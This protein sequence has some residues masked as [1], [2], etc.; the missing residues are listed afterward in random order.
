MGSIDALLW[1]AQ[2]PLVDVIGLLSKEAK[3][4]KVALAT[5][6]AISSLFAIGLC[7]VSFSSSF[8]SLPLFGLSFLFFKVASRL[9]DYDNFAELQIMKQEAKNLDFFK[10]IQDHQGIEPILVHEI[11]SHSELRLKFQSELKGRSLA[12]LLEDIPLSSIIKHH[13]L[14]REEI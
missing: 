1:Q 6:A 5:F 12:K 8:L 13:L 3:I 7:T 9:K 14:K 2:A 4:K 10:L 11:I